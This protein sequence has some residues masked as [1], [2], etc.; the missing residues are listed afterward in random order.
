MFAMPIPLRSDFAAAQVRGFAKRAKD[1]PQARRLLALAAIYDGATRTQA[2]AIG[3]VTL[4]IVRDWVV[5]FNAHGPDGLI[6]RKAPGGAAL[7][8]QRIRA[9]VQRGEQPSAEP[10]RGGSEHHTVPNDRQV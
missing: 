6:D 3:G 1:G 5:K 2:A 8:Y 9:F 7:P 4:Q 10:W